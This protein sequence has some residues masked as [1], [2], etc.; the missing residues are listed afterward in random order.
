ML[1]KVEGIVLTEKDYKETS[2]IL[3]VFT[4]K[5]G[6]IGIISK[7]CKSLKSDLRSGSSKLSYGIFS[8]YYKEGK[9]STLMSVDVLDSFKHIKT[10]IEAISF[11][12]Y[13]LELTEQVVKQIHRDGIYDLLIDA[14]KKINEGFDPMVIT[15]IVELKYLEYLGVMP[16][17]DSCS[18][19]G[20]KTGITTLA[21]DKGGYVCKKCYTNEPMVEEKTIKLIRLFYYVDLGKISKLDVSS[22][23]KEEINR[24]LD[25][26]YDRYTGLYLKSKN[27][28]K[29][30]N[31][32][33]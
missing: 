31:K 17:L 19:C 7:G 26:Y 24:F 11:A 14:L 30:L 12:S 2:K 16:I 13:L 29:N 32:I 20:S 1:D 33:S 23:V 21:S 15:N 27:F 5:Y 28:I 25:D 6:V 4:K 3:N 10:N 18:I 22:K 9:L 8:I